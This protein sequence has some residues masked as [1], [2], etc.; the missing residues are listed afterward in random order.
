MPQLKEV[1]LDRAQLEITH[2]CHLNNDARLAFDCFVISPKEIGSSK[3]T[4]YGQPH[5]V[6]YL[7]F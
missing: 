1:A 2:K 5:L 3:T 7:S 4:L 6:S